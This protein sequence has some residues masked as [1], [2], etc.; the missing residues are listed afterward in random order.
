MRARQTARRRFLKEGATLAGLAVAA[1]S[2]SGQTLGGAHAEHPMAFGERSRFVEAQRTPMTQIGHVDMHGE[3]N[4]LDATTPLGE[5]TGIITPA[6]LHYVSQHMNAPEDIDPREHRLMISGMVDRPLVFTLDEL[7]RLPSVSRIHYIEC[8]ANRPNPRERTLEELAGMVSCSEWTGVLLSVLLNEAGVQDGASWI[9]GESADNVGLGTNIPLPKAM[10]DVIVAYGQN[11]EPVRPHQGF[12]LRLVTPGFEGKYHVKY[13]KRVRVLDR[14]YMTYWEQSH[15]TNYPQREPLSYYLEQGPKSVITFPSAGGQPL[16]DRG[17][18]TIGG[19]AWSG[20]GTVRRVEVSTDDGRTWNDAQLPEP[21]LRV[22]FTRFQ[23]PWT[24]NGQE[25]VLQS[26]CTDDQGQ[27][28]PTAAEHNAFWGD[29]RPPHGN[30]I[31]P[32]RV[33]SGGQ[34]LNAL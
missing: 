22:A 11:G 14:P 20:C 3:P 34:I 18:Y 26:R 4:G 31:Q 10:D 9:I 15:F 7:K 16:R 19:L 12:P 13:L 5:L 27:V 2:V 24:W 17:F 32:W 1:R 29:A 28:Q 6:D 23:L 21:A 25:T 8:I 33:T 30:M